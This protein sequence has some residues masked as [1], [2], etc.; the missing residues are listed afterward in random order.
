[1][2]FTETN[3]SIYPSEQLEESE[4]CAKVECWKCDG[5]KLNKKGKKPCKKCGG[6]GFIQTQFK[7]DF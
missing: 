4:D 5:T 6:Q 1:M 3:V 2:D 7:G